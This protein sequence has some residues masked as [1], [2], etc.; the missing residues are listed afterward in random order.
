MPNLRRPGSLRVSRL[1]WGRRYYCWQDQTI[2]W[3]VQYTGKHG[4][5]FLSQPLSVK[6]K[7]NFTTP[8]T[9]LSIWWHHIQRNDTAAPEFLSD[10][11]LIDLIHWQRITIAIAFYFQTY[12]LDSFYFLSLLY[13]SWNMLRTSSCFCLSCY[14]F[15]S[16]RGGNPISTVSCVS[17][18]SCT[19]VW[20]GRA[21]FPARG[22][23]CLQCCALKQVT[24]WPLSSMAAGI[25]LG[26]SLT[27]WLTE[28]VCKGCPLLHY[29][30]VC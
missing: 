26:S 1:L 3:K 6:Q 29:Q 28:M 17:P 18:R 11:L 14:R 5:A 12:Q 2:L 23:S 19:T 13:F 4:R 15:I 8:E 7:Q 27:A 25:L 30:V 9:G 21:A 24:T 10:F 16:I 20:G 22:W